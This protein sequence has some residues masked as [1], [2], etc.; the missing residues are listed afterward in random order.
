MLVL[1]LVGIIVLAIVKHKFRNASSETGSLTTDEEHE[2]I[3]NQESKDHNRG[4][5]V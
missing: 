2:K 5:L 1:G 4:V 3:E